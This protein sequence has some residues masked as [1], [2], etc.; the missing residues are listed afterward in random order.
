MDAIKATLG[1]RQK[2]RNDTVLF[3]TGMMTSKD[4][5]TERARRYMKKKFVDD[6]DEEIPLYK[7]YRLCEENNTK[8]YHFIRDCLSSEP[9]E[10]LKNLK[11]K[12]VNELGSKAVTYK[13]IN[14]SLTVHN[15]YCTNA[16]I[17]EWKRVN[18][19]RFRLSSHSLKIETGRWSRILREERLCE[20]GE[21]Q[22]ELHVTLYCPKTAGIREKFNFDGID[23]LNDL[24]KHP[25]II[26]I[27]NEITEIFK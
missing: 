6:V 9:L 23:N 13:S 24:M 3:E 10:N 2:T 21:V 25:S 20:C 15:V 17:C 14:S 16:Y 18:F 11:D 5:I 7:I 19:T 4:M 1:V 22:D 12:F 26:D 27:I 8:G